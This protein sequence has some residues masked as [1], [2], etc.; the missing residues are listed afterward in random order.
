MTRRTR[1]RSATGIGRGA[2]R[3]AIEAALRKKAAGSGRQA[4]SHNRSRMSTANDK[5]N[6]MTK[7][8]QEKRNA[9]RITRAA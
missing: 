4:Q 8:A 1:T 3:D 9:S 5:R 7:K 6:D 2:R